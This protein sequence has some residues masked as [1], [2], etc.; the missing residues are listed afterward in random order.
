[1]FEKLNLNNL[2]IEADVIKFNILLIEFKISA[3]DAI[4]I[5]RVS[6]KLIFTLNNN[7]VLRNAKKSLRDDLRLAAGTVS[8]LVNPKVVLLI[9][10]QL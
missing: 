4:T 3:S 2:L 6:R 5:K 7:V 8:R 1:M 10:F 9:K